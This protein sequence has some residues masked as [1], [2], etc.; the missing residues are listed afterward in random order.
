MPLSKRRYQ[1]TYL[2]ASPAYDIL[3]PFYSLTGL[4]RFSSFSLTS[5]RMNNT[6]A[7]ARSNPTISYYGLTKAEGIAISSAFNC[8]LFLNRRWKLSHNCSICINK[9]TSQEKSFLGYKHGGFW[10]TAGSRILAYLHFSGAGFF[11]TRESQMEPIFSFLL[12]RR[13]SLSGIASYCC[14]DLPGEVSRHLLAV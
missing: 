12:H 11:Q 1:F 8:G 2:L 7:I 5:Q 3:S 10:S 6:T 14:V 13:L 9:E 4:G